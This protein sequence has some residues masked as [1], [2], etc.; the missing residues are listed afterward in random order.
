MDVF[1][2]AHVLRKM[3]GSLRSL[4]LLPAMGTVGQK[5]GPMAR[6]SEFRDLV[7]IWT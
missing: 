7:T 3:E 4:E 2:D 6:E 5:F 1:L